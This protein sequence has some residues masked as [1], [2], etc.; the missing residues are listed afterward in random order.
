LDGQYRF[1]GNR[2]SR[3]PLDRQPRVADQGTKQPKR[4][5]FD[6]PDDMT[7]YDQEEVAADIVGNGFICHDDRV[8]AGPV[9]K[10]FV[11]DSGN[12]HHGKVVWVLTP[13]GK[14]VVADA[15]TMTRH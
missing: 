8:I 12:R 14:L 1:K 15:Q 4:T 5:W 11:A 13:L 10:G 9:S 7:S 3:D 2:R 6:M